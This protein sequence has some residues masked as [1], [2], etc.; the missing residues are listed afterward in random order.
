MKVLG[1]L[2][3]P[4]EKTARQPEPDGLNQDEFLMPHELVVRESFQPRSHER[5][6]SAATGEGDGYLSASSPQ[7]SPPACAGRRGS[8]IATGFFRLSNCSQRVNKIF[9]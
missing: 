7:P 6:H 3:R 1:N 5:G 2:G 9:Q 4:H 8:R